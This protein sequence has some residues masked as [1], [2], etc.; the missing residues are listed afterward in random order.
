MDRRRFS[1]LGYDGPDGVKELDGLPPDP[2]D[3]T[4]EFWSSADE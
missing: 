4:F 1:G 2:D 3:R